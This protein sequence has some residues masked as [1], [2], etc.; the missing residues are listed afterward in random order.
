MSTAMP[1][2]AHA[3]IG[4]ALAACLARPPATAA[5]ARRRELAE[6]A[7][8]WWSDTARWWSERLPR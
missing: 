3:L 5:D 6:G 1:T 2:L 7:A 8:R 4:A